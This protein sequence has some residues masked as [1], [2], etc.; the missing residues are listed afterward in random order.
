[1]SMS[2]LLLMPFSIGSLPLLLGVLPGIA[3]GANW[4][5]SGPKE[6]RLVVMKKR[7]DDK[8]RWRTVGVA[9][10]PPSARVCSAA[11]SGVSSLPR[12]ARKVWTARRTIRREK[13]VSSKH[14]LRHCCRL[15]VVRG[16]CT[17]IRWV[18]R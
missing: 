9:G 1:M 7:T 13:R 18:G 11:T 4:C 12:A 16:D 17:A 15:Y 2:P 6:S 8:R 5:A 14:Q 3:A 10:S